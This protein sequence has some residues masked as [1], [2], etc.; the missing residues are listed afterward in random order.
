MVNIFC[1]TIYFLCVFQSDEVEAADETGEFM[2]DTH[3]RFLHFLPLSRLL[4]L[5]SVSPSDLRPAELDRSDASQSS[6]EPP[7][8]TYKSSYDNISFFLSSSLFFNSLK[9]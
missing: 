1:I 8:C 3:K 6:T 5:P 2:A 4:F 9:L 7:T